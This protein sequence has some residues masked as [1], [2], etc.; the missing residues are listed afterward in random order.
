MKYW[1]TF[2]LSS[3]VYLICFFL[4]YIVELFSINET[5]VKTTIFGLKIV[6]KMTMHSLNTTFSLTWYTLLTYVIF[7]LLCELAVFIFYLL[8]AVFF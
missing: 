4:D 6:T 1:K 8:S 5:S 7:V 3:L 2:T